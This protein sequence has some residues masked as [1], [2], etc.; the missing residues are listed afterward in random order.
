MTVKEKVL[1]RLG[2]E[3][4][5]ISGEKLAAELGVS[6]TAVWKAIRELQ[7]EGFLF[8]AVQNRGYK[9]L[10][11]PEFSAAVLA[12]ELDAERSELGDSLQAPE[13]FASLGTLVLGETESTNKVARELAAQNAPETL[14]LAAKQ[15]AGRGRLGRSFYS[16]DGSGLYMSLLLY[17]GCTAADASVIT[18]AAAVAVCRALERLDPSLKP[19]IKWVNDVYLG[20]RKVC[21]ILTEGQVDFETGTLAFAV[22]GIGV[23]IYSPTEGWTPDIKNRA[24][25]VYSEP[26]GELRVRLAAMIAAEFFRYYPSLK[27]SDFIEYYRERMFLTGMEVTVVPIGGE[28]YPAV[29]VGVDDELKLIVDD[30]REQKRLSTGEVSLKLGADGEMHK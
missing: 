2:R 17:P 22:P 4:D 19:E 3:K 18:T 16:P 1:D 28:T 12:R 15:T 23:N 8:E 10:A 25:A 13:R 14:I 11:S 5:S 6:R 21:G 26:H 20:G 30:G 27:I 7:S 29:V 9:L 24:G